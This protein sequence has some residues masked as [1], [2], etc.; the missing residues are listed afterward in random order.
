MLLHAA[1]ASTAEGE[2][3][4]E[5]A[6]EARADSPFLDRRIGAIVEDM[7][8][9]GVTVLGLW[10]KRHSQIAVHVLEGLESPN[11]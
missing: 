1:I 11:G 6:Q 2:L 5:H 8:G 10:Q 4:G 3:L 9:G 7:L